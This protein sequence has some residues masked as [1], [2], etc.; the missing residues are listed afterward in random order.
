[1]LVRNWSSLASVALGCAV[2]WGCDTSATSDG[3]DAGTLDAGPPDAGFSLV[4]DPPVSAPSQFVDATDDWNLGPDGL[5]LT[6][7][8]I[9]S[10]DLDGD[11]YPDLV[12]SSGATNVRSNLDPDA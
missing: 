3:G 4:C 10:A 7:N 9:I 12:V 5:K 8:R 6:G 11:G 2:L 1:M